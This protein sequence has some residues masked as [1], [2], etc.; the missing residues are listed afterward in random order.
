MS[1]ILKSSDEWL[2]EPKYAGITVLDPDG[3]DRSNYD[4]S[5]AEQISELEFNRRVGMSTI[6]F[7]P[8]WLDQLLNQQVDTPPDIRRAINENLPSLL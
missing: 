4:V 1:E 8:E 2:K 5:W 7:T 3:W 6:K